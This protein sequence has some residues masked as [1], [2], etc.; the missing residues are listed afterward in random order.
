M[1]QHPWLDPSAF[2]FEGGPIG[3]LLVHGFTGSPPE[4]KPLG[5]YLAQQ[6]LTVSG[7]L[8]AG[9]GTSYQDMERTTWQDW[10]ASAEAAYLGLREECQQVFVGGLSMGSLMALRLAALHPVD[11]IITY[12]P[13]IKVRDWRARFVRP[14]RH[15]IRWERKTGSQEDSD[16]TDPEAHKMLWSYD[17]IPVESAHQ[18]MMLQKDVRRRLPHISTP[19]LIIQSVLDQAIHPDSGDILLRSIASSDKELVVLRN[20]GHCVTV[21]SEREAVWRKT[22]SWISGRVGGEGEPS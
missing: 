4:M 9:H 1:T 7:P 12:S 20:S 18:L 15:I 19:I 10:Y 3:C 16:L 21:D 22:Y 11:G 5:E 2:H 17:V 8:L 13:A 6:G 14:M